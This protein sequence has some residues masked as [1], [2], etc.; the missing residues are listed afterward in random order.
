MF[1]SDR[2]YLSYEDQQKQIG[3]QREA[4]K[5]ARSLD[6]SGIA[7]VLKDTVTFERILQLKE[8]LDRIDIPAFADLYRVAI[9]RCS[10]R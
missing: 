2:F 9:R 3:A 7:P 5:I 4:P 1:K 10:L 8:I 6:V